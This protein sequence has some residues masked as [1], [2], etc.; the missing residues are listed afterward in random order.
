MGIR[1]TLNKQ[2]ASDVIHEMHDALDAY[3]TVTNISLNPEQDNGKVV[4][5]SIRMKIDLDTISRQATNKILA[6][7]KLTL[8]EAHG[9]V[10]ISKLH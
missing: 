9:Y 8:R 3:V 2:E 6:K 4:G 10:F 1:D 7:H 5:Y